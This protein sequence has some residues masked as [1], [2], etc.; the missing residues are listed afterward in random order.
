M[1]QKE[2]VERHIEDL[3]TFAVEWKCFTETKQH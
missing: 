1:K 2:E 3:E